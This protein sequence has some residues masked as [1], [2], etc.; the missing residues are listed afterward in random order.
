MARKPRAFA[1]AAS[2]FCRLRTMLASCMSRSTVR[3]VES[4]HLRRVEIRERTRDSLSRLRRIVHQL[5]PG[6]RALEHEE[7]E[8]HAVVAHGHAPLLS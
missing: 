4:R 2:I 8:V 3:G 6:L 7:L 5:K 1:I